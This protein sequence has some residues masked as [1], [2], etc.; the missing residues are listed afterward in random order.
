MSPNLQPPDQTSPREAFVESQAA[1]QFGTPLFASLEMDET[2][3][4]LPPIQAATG[5]ESFFRMPPITHAAP[6][7]P[8]RERDVQALVELFHQEE[9]AA[10]EADILRNLLWRHPEPHW[11]D[12]ESDLLRDSL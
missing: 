2:I 1:E 10:I 7:L 3:A 8:L 6:L 12:F 9:I 4:S 11:D 5:A